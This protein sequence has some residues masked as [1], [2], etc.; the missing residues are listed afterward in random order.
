MKE[1]RRWFESWQAERIGEMQL[2]MNVSRLMGL[3]STVQSEVFR[4]LT[5]IYNNFIKDPGYRTMIETFQVRYQVSLD[6]AFESELLITSLLGD[7]H[8]K[9]RTEL[10]SILAY[11][12]ILTSA[13]RN[14]LS[15]LQLFNYAAAAFHHFFA[16]GAPHVSSA[17]SN[18]VRA[19]RLWP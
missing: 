7:V 12:R 5:T 19:H 14:G 13:L 3:F 2:F 8:K 9:R 15:S 10:A 6:I 16:C 1:L 11:I 4:L 18:K 17:V